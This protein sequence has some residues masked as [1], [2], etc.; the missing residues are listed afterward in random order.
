M[1]VS[2]A[3]YVIQHDC[4]KYHSV[5]LKTG[6]CWKPPDIWNLPKYCAVKPE[7]IAD[8]RRTIKSADFIGEIRTKFYCYIYRR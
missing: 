7:S 5:S 4:V 1:T 3:H 2:V 8:D 6:I